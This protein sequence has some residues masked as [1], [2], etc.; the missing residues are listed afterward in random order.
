MIEN[1]IHVQLSVYNAQK[2]IVSHVRNALIHIFYSL[3][4][5]FK[6]V[7]LDIFQMQFLKSV[8]LV[9]L[10]VKLALDQHKINAKL[11]FLAIIIKVALVNV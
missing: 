7:H 1:V 2:I 11:V 9:F 8:N 5:A 4:H 3:H 6:Y 10:H